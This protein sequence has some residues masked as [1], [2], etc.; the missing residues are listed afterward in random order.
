MLGEPKIADH[1]GMQQAD[2]VGGGGIAEPGKK[3]F[4]DRRTAD[5]RAAL[6]HSHLVSRAGEIAGASQPVVTA[7]DDERVNRFGIRHGSR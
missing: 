2:R 6:E 4:R 5:H 3:L 7:P 1:L